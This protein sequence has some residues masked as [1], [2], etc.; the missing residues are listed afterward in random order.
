MN[1]IIDMAGVS[2]GICSDVD[3]F[4][5]AV[6]LPVQ[7]HSCNV[8]EVDSPRPL[9]D[10]DAIIT[11]TPG[12]RIGVRTADCVPLLLHAPDIRAIA[13]IHAGWKGSLGDITGN[14]VRRLTEAGASPQLM[15][16]AFGPS[17]CGVCYEV[18][19]ELA[20]NFRRAGFSDCISGN[21]H[22]DLEAVNRSRLLALGLKAENIRPKPM[23]T[24]EK[25]ALPSWRRNA[26]T[27]RLLTWIMLA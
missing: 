12:L 18:S 27:S 20:D 2:A 1:L 7:T 22:V 13:A 4:S 17:I 26:T 10:T 21:R 6:L 24:F 14:T 11:R 3:R 15:Q 9:P 23:C 19:A 8:A 25:H 5:H 16:A